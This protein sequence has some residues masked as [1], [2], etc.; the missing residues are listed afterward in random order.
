MSVLVFYIYFIASPKGCD[1]DQNWLHQVTHTWKIMISSPLQ[2]VK[3]KV[4]STKEITCKRWNK[5]SM[6]KYS[7]V[8]YF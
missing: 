5:T 1:Q 8:V 7:E 6:N 4:A 2:S 3:E